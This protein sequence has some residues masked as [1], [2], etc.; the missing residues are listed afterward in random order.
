MG[1]DVINAFVIVV[2]V[3]M[4][5]S[6]RAARA[7]QQ[8]TTQVQPPFAIMSCGTSCVGATCWLIIA[9]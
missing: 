2:Q 3:D 1:C 8:Q 7:E 5:D 4:A 9:A 6:E